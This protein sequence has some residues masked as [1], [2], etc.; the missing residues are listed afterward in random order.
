[1]QNES[2]ANEDNQETK[3]MSDNTTREVRSRDSMHSKIQKNEQNDDYTKII[4]GQSTNKTFK[5]KMT[6]MRDH[7]NLLKFKTSGGAQ[8]N[9][10]QQGIRT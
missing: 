8:A 7:I 9:K 4:R 1:V 2:R 6:K 10:Y 3:I 5:G